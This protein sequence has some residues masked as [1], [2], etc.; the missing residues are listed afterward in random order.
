MASGPYRVLIVDD[1][2]TVR[3]SL[4]WLLETENGLLVAGEAQRVC[5]KGPRWDSPAERD[6]PGAG[7]RERQPAPGRRGERD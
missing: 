4:R 7:R 6:P 1:T 5:R 2:D 3:E